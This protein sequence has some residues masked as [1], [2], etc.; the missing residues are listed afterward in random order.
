M[1]TSSFLRRVLL[2]TILLGAVVAVLSWEPSSESSRWQAQV[3][4]SSSSSAVV[5][6]SSFSSVAS[7]SVNCSPCTNGGCQ[8]CS[9]WADHP[10]CAIPLSAGGS[11]ECI[12]APTAGYS[13]CTCGASSSVSS[14]NQS[15]SLPSSS[16]PQ[17]SSATSQVAS[18]S[19]TGS[20]FSSVAQQSSSTTGG[21]TP[22]GAVI[23]LEAG[24]CAQVKPDPE[25]G[26]K[27]VYCCLDEGFI[28]QREAN[29]EEYE[30]F[31]A[32]LKHLESLSAKDA[33]PIFEAPYDG[34][35]HKKYGWTSLCGKQIPCDVCSQDHICGNGVVEATEKCDDGPLN[36][37]E[38]PDTCRVDCTLPDCGDNVIDLQ[39][40]EECDD[41]KFNGNQPN[42]CRTDC[43]LP[44]C[45][46]GIID[47]LSGETCDAGKDNS[48][49]EA[50]SC[51][52]NCQSPRCG[53][54]VKDTN[55]ECDD[56]NRTDGDGCSFYCQLEKTIPLSS[57]PTVRCGNGIMESGEECDSGSTNANIP[58]SC[59]QNCVLPRCGDRIQDAEEECDDG[60]T[61]N[62][63][64][65]TAQCVRELVLSL[66]NVCGNQIIDPGEEC[67]AGNGNTNIPDHCRFDC[68]FPICGDGIRDTHEQC[69]DRNHQEGDGCT[70]DC[71]S[72]FCGDG[73][74]EMGEACDDGNLISG[75][76]CS[77]LCQKDTGSPVSALI[78]QSGSLALRG[79]A[80]SR[81]SVDS[82]LPAP[83][84]SST[85][86]VNAL[87]PD[88][89][90]PFS[91][92]F[93][94]GPTA[95]M[96]LFPAAGSPLTP[97]PVSPY[98]YMQQQSVFTTSSLNDT[99]PAA[100]SIV[101]MGAAAGFAWARRRRRN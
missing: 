97:T 50:N 9:I 15:S 61:A 20:Q 89:D 95:Q 55:E 62:G 4:T 36:S 63:D 1:T 45:G 25:T 98:E 99:G 19:S 3:L 86:S 2:P 91:N 71:F 77:R 54:N 23:G 22:N 51:R 8:A 37:D 67:D 70:K 29:Q 49:T 76:G 58:N 43:L 40:G 26:Q 92:S 93:V 59:R 101:A 44:L 14:T 79:A 6:S 87:F 80:S 42:H 5:A 16:V 66:T 72:E 85:H 41:G 21:T 81:S 18:A 100:L 53:D 24:L 96:I 94:F 69:D 57:L 30:Q 47:S 38:V 32:L 48:D 84:Q 31:V 11:Y 82:L 60:N 88:V 52:N 56:G 12:A 83:Q 78:V 7:V 73:F 27:L 33:K 10:L 17:S 28:Y 35:V 34:S 39:K 46:D 90:F 65:C 13:V 75:D 64:G 74:I 68:R